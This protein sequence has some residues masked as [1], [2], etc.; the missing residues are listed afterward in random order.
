MFL[1]MFVRPG[2][3]RKEERLPQSFGNSA[4]LHT[5][6]HRTSGLTNEK[7]FLRIPAGNTPDML[8]KTIEA[9]NDSDLAFFPGEPWLMLVITLSEW[10]D[11]DR[12]KRFSFI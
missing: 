4:T 3:W 7:H 2:K 8:Q 9:L 6:L 10:Y 1:L 12:L 11:R 5:F